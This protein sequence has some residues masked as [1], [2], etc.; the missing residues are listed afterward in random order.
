MTLPL[1]FL[2][3][4]AIEEV[5]VDVWAEVFDATESPM[6]TSLRHCRKISSLTNCCT[7]LKLSMS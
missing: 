6:R 1:A 3:V 5:A 4:T 2:D 7:P